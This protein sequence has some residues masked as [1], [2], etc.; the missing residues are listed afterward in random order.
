MKEEPC[1]LCLRAGGRTISIFYDG[2]LS[3]QIQSEIV[4]CCPIEILRDD[5]LPQVI[6]IECRAKLRATYEFR[7]QCYE[8]DRK[9]R[10]HERG[11]SSGPRASQA[12]KEA[13]TA[14]GPV[15]PGQLPAWSTEEERSSGAGGAASPGEI[16][17][18][19][20]AVDAS[21]G[22]RTA[23]MEDRG[24]EAADLH[25][26]TAS[27]ER[28]GLSRGC[29]ESAA[30]LAR[31][32]GAEGPRADSSHDCRRSAGRIG[33]G[34]NGRRKGATCPAGAKAT[35]KEG[36]TSLRP[37]SPRERERA[38]R[39]EEKR[40][41]CDVCSKRF[42]SKSGLRF[43]LKMHDGSKP[44]VCQ[45][46]DKRF[47][48]PSYKKRHERIHTGGKRLVCHVCSAAFASSNGL[49]YH[50]RAHSGEA[51]YHCQICGKSFGR[52]KYLK[53]HTFTHTGER[54]FVCKICGSTYGNSGSLF[55]HERKCK[56]RHP[57]VASNLGSKAIA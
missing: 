34:Q 56:I 16:L 25:R 21:Y 8:S 49:K 26:S 38:T 9:L 41:L 45:F 43:H 2:P 11:W 15:V 39:K 50:L 35:A 53:E 37:D 17:E 1:R 22:Q 51:N 13:P 5:R 6:C 23:G 42:A 44:H 14:V 40:Y 29:K 4:D 36:A 55:V 18:V 24:E 19:D 48:I 12:L 31:D 3:S 20:V 33:R 52:Y 27:S 30:T 47:A 46:C 54:P 32:S 7:K 10:E 57:P 28:N